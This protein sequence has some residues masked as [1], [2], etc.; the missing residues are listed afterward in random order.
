MD[1]RDPVDQM[2]E[3]AYAG[4]PAGAFAYASDGGGFHI[5][6]LLRP[7]VP[8]G[9]LVAAS[10]V[11]A[12]GVLDAMESLGVDPGQIGIAWPQDVVRVEGHEPLAR[13]TTRAGYG[14][15]MFVVAR[16]ALEAVGEERLA[17]ALRDALV[18]RSERWGAAVQ[19][20]LAQA[21]PWAPFLDEYF[22]RVALMGKPVDVRYPNGR[23]YA[24]G[25]FVGLDVWGHAT[26]RTKRAG[27]L[28]FPT[29][30]FRIA[31]QS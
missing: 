24:R 13:V 28:E 22:G 20:G 15:G 25:Y 31:P 30:R 21:G 26:V 18:G 6:V 5:A 9:Q 17:Y 8:M 19:A 10:P 29:E 23:V 4:E 3:S 27:D 16:V 2:L 14:D 7:E 1:D 12:L 11:V